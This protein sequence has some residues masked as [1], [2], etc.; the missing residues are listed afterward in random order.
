MVGVFVVVVLA[1]MSRVEAGDAPARARRKP[2]N[3]RRDNIMSERGA[4]VGRRVR[5]VVKQ[6]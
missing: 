5:D 6:G 3:A 2:K 1:E 4:I